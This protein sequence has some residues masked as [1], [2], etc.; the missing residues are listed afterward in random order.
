MRM[1]SGDQAALASEFMNQGLHKCFMHH[2]FSV[3]LVSIA[4]RVSIHT[5]AIA[6]HTYHLETNACLPAF[7]LSFQTSTQTGPRH[8]RGKGGKG[9]VRACEA[10]NYIVHGVPQSLEC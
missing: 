2:F 4:H 8:R 10:Q 5:H 9:G 3:F 6:P 1:V 7:S